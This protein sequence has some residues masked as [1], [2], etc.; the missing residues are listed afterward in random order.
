MPGPLR[1]D[2]VFPSGEERLVIVIYVDRV[3]RGIPYLV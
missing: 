2:G 3:I 1:S